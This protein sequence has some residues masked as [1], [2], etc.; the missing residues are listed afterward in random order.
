M[1][2]YYNPHPTGAL[3]DDCVKRALCVCT[4]IDYT[5]LSQQLVGFCR[6]T[7]AKRYYTDRNPHRF[8]EDVLGA[9]KIKTQDKMTVEDF[10]RSHS[11]GRYVLG[12]HG[13]WT[14]CVDGCI[15]DTWDCLKQAVQYAY[16]FDM[17]PYQQPDVRRQA[18]R[19][20]C[21][22]HRHS[23]GL[24]CIRIYDGNGNFSQRI[25]S[26]DLTEGYVLC[27]M[28]SKYQ[29]INLDKGESYEG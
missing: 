25:I 21:T 6:V 8:A 26:S 17:Q 27:L 19:Y 15:Y 7:G 5:I 13:H 28:H 24:D 11:R 4:G 18:F 3:L 2:K 14:A 10:A 20:C 1:F 9:K 12:L 29:Y 22:S 23:K 16:A